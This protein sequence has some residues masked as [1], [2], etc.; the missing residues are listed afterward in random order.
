[1]ESY[2]LFFFIL[3]SQ[4]RALSILDSAL[5]SV[6]ADL[7]SACSKLTLLDLNYILY[8]CREEELCEYGTDV[9]D[10]P[11]YGPLPYA[12]LQGFNSILTTM[13]S[14]KDMGHP[15]ATNLRN[16]DWAMSYITKRLIREKNCAALAMWLQAQF[17]Q[18][19]RIPRYLVPKYFEGILSLVH[20]VLR[21]KAWYA[22]LHKQEKMSH[23]PR[24]K[25]HDSIFLFL[26][27]SD[28]SL[29]RIRISVLAIPG[30]GI[31]STHGPDHQRLSPTSQEQ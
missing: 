26:Q 28:V 29:H 18:I 5:A 9:Y 6:P 3:Q 20:S 27:L 21:E 10:I 19:E 23:C 30:I 1:M 25:K 16:G 11:G 31:C 7:E 8:R 24:Q 4:K 14:K 15:L 13:K 22:E 17:E 2:F 12:G